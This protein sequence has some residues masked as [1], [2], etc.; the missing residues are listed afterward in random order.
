MAPDGET[1][2]L[3]E[4]YEVDAATLVH[5]DGNLGHPRIYRRTSVELEDGTRADAYLTTKCHGDDP[6][7]EPGDWR[8]REEARAKW[9][10]RAGD[11]KITAIPV[12][13]CRELGPHDRDAVA[14][15]GLDDQRLAAAESSELTD[16]QRRRRQ[17]RERP[18][19]GCLLACPRRSWSWA[20]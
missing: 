18:A 14:E 2:V 16:G 11:Q 19:A 9:A 15:I 4:I 20:C 10:V 7:I 6:Q 5:L 17:R 13:G 8:A 1:A 12:P 3:G